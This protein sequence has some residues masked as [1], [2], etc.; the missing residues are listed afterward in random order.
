M[1]DTCIFYEHVMKYVACSVVEVSIW[2]LVEDEFVPNSVLT[3]TR[4]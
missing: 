2:L 3:Q 1:Y 4:L